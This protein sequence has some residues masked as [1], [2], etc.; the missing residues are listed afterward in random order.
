MN[1]LNKYWNKMK[2]ATQ[3]MEAEIESL[4][5]TKPRGNWK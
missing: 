3:G 1:M 4:K 2:E 5:E